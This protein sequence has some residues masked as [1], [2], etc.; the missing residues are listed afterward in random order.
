MKRIVVMAVGLIIGVNDMHAM[1]LLKCCFGRE[2]H[3]EL[4]E[5][6]DES[7]KEYTYER[8]LTYE[9]PGARFATISPDNTQI[10]SV[11][12]T[13][14]M[15]KMLTDKQ[16]S[17]TYECSDA[18]YA[19]FSSDGRKALIG[20]GLQLISDF[21]M[22]RG[23]AVLDL[24]QGTSFPKCFAHR[25]FEFLAFTPNEKE[26]IAV[27]NRH[28]R[29]EAERIN[30]VDYATGQIKHSAKL[31]D[32]DV[33]ACFLRNS[34]LYALLKKSECAQRVDVSTYVDLPDVIYTDSMVKDSGSTF[35]LKNAAASNDKI[36][37]VSNISDKLGSK[38]HDEIRV[39]D[40]ESGD[41]VSTISPGKNGLT[42]LGPIAISS[43]S[44]KLAFGAHGECSGC[45]GDKHRASLICIA[46]LEGNS[47]TI[48]HQICIHGDMV[49]SITFSPDNRSIFVI[50]DKSKIIDVQTGTKV[51][52]CVNYGRGQ[53]SADGTNA[54]AV[55][56]HDARPP[57]IE[58]AERKWALKK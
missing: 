52:S 44:K 12:E 14:V 36:A 57:R 46:N 41:I 35:L 51:W 20:G 11:A 53:F 45:F 48:A 56:S 34:I 24:A 49:F 13:S 37:I 42:N 18:S 58:I 16:T 25:G 22:G 39:H 29:V 8:K 2:N 43:D 27:H 21:N 31:K 47:A 26:I 7:S 15:I 17:T 33:A 1:D 4:Q 5:E 10:L 23:F 19:A 38:A 55:A 28:E 40:L 6:P 30:I 3:V 50:G 32:E 9:H 54:V